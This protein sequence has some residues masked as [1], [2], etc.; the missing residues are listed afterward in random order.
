M[1]TQTQRVSFA[2]YK[3]GDSGI[4]DAAYGVS[5]NLYAAAAFPTPPVTKPDLDA[6]ITAMETAKAAM[7]Q[8]GTAATAERNL[9]KQDLYNLLKQLAYYVNVES[10]NDLAILLSSGFEAVSTDRLSEQL[11]AP[12][13]VTVK[14]GMSRQSLTT[15]KAVKNSRGYEMQY[16]L[17]DESTGTNGPW[18][19]APFSTS[20]RNIPV[21]GLE[22]GKLYIYR[23][24][25]MG[26]L[27][28]QSDWSEGVSHR[29]Y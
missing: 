10:K 17:V 22:S 16:S 3:K 21:N 1:K 20:S 29:A 11:P 6:A 9:R 13:Y 25:A 7:V 28:G 12:S 5:A 15:A 2:F 26:G 27:T 23:V 19:D 18:M 4:L 24:R 14:N 8:G